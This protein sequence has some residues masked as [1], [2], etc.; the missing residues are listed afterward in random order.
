MACCLSVPSHYLNK[1]WPFVGRVLRNIISQ[2]M[3]K[4]SIR[5]ANQKIYFRQKVKMC[6]KCVDLSLWVLQAY[7]SILFHRFRP[8][9]A[10]DHRR[11][12]LV[13][14]IRDGPH[15]GYRGGHQGHHSSLEE[16]EKRCMRSS[17][18]WRH[19]GPDCVSNHQPYNC[20]LNRLFGRK[21]K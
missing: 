20:L 17:L 12:P 8:N 10:P 4:Y 1:Y 3:L 15:M 13:C 5:K 21:S 7:Q 2:E 14:S 6:W 16:N 11:S 18:R 9:S 19:N